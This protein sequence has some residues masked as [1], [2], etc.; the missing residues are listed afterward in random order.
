MANVYHVF[1]DSH[2]R[3]FFPGDGLVMERLGF[4]S[5][6]LVVKGQAISAAS[7]AG[8]RKQQSTLRTREIV[9]DAIGPARKMV[10]A[11]GQVDLELGYYYRKI[12]KGEMSLE[13]EDYSAWLVD[14]Y[15]ALIEGLDLSDLDLALKGSNLTVLSNPEFAV[16]YILRIIRPK[17]RKPEDIEMLRPA[18]LSEDEQNGLILAFNTRLRAFCDERGLRYFDINDGLSVDGEA[19]RPARL[20]PCFMPGGFDHHITDSLEVRALHM[21]GLMGVFEDGSPA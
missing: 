15:R 1:G 11:F 9:A 20:R 7:L 17:N 4:G 21:K 19:G 13:P 12:I 10:L 8:F 18:L 6:D 14:A 16:R 2:A 5:E 3:L